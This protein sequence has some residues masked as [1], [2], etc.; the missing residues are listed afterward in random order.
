VRLDPGQ[1]ERG[2]AG[3]VVDL[4]DG[5]EGGEEVGQAGTIAHHPAVAR[6]SGADERAGSDVEG[7]VAEQ[8]VHARNVRREGVDRAAQ[9]RVAID[10][11]AG[12]ARLR[13]GRLGCAEKRLH[14]RRL[15]LLHTCAHAIASSVWRGA[16]ARPRVAASG[17]K[18]P[19]ARRQ[20][21]SAPG[22]GPARSTKRPGHARTIAVT[23]ASAESLGRRSP[24]IESWRWPTSGIGCRRKRGK[25]GGGDGKRARIHGSNS[26]LRTGAAR[27]DPR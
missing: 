16:A 22:R 27:P 26:R 3:Q 4:G 19:A 5:R 21:R 10:V 12:L 6:Q 14:E 9:H 15:E 18:R 11:G 25:G 7:V 8:A 23:G 2:D 20:P 24:R 1:V 13:Q 17:R